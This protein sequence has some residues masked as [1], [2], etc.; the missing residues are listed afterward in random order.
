MNPE[1]LNFHAEVLFYSFI[2]IFICTAVLTMLG[3]AGR[4]P[5]G[6][7]Y[8]K[9]LFTSLLLEVVGGIVSLYKA[10]LL[11]RPPE[12]QLV[13]QDFYESISKHDYQHAYS[14]IDPDSNFRKKYSF[15]VFKLGYEDTISVNLLAIAPISNAAKDNNHEYAVYY[16]DEINMRTRPDLDDLLS[17]RFENIQTFVSKLE[18][19]RQDAVA[20]G[21]K[22]S[23]INNLTFQQLSIINS[24]DRIANLLIRDSNIT[25]ADQKI[26]DLFPENRII[27][28]VRSYQL[29]LAEVNKHWYI[30][31]FSEE[32]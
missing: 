31:R 2:G 10:E 28:A 26:S 32:K 17:I 6:Q 14:L 22:A 18:S 15:E 5:I 23:T 25:N 11:F 29:S 4:I 19:L 1:N 21:F 27:R 8:L 12:S 20:S 13:V 7:G 16:Y 9:A 24:Q 30:E 3:I